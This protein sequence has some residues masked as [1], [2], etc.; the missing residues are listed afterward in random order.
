VGIAAYARVIA[1]MAAAAV[2]AVALGVLLAVAT[3]SDLA[4]IAGGCC[5]LFVGTLVAARNVGVIA[6]MSE[7]A[8]RV[9]EK[10]LPFTLGGATVL[11]AS[12]VGG[13]TGA[14]PAVARVLLVVCGLAIF[15]CGQRLYSL[16]P[17][18]DS[19]A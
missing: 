11:L 16:P 5:L 13:L 19:P 15:L 2:I 17:N 8:R 18:S 1:P 9:H 14:I 3:G 7:E 4:G 10:R 12:P 6:P